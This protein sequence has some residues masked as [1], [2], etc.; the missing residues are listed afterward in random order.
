LFEKFTALW[1]KFWNDFIAKQYNKIFKDTVKD[2]SQKWRDILS[3]NLLSIVANTLNNL[4]NIEATFDIESD[5]ILTEPLKDLCKD[6]EAKRYDIFAET[7]C[8]GDYYVFP[9]TNERGELYHSYLTQEQVRILDM[10]GDKIT[11]AYGIIEWYVDS[12]TNRTYYLLRHHVLDVNGTLTISYYVVDDTNKASSLPQWEHLQDT[13]LQYANANHIGFGR[14]KSPVS[15][16]GLSP[17]YGVPL[18]YGCAE[19]EERIFNTL[20]LM[21]AE[22]EN[23]KSV[24]FTDPRNLLTDEEKKQYKLAENV[25]PTSH[26]SGDNSAYIDIFNPTLRQSEF[27]GKLQSDFAVYEKQLGASKGVLSDSETSNGATAT[28]VRRIN[29]DTIA[30]IG[31]FHSAI[32]D[33]NKMTLEADAVYLNIPLVLWSYV[34]DWYDPFED[35]AA[36]WQR[37]LEAHNAGAITTARLTKWVYPNMTDE[38]VQNELAEISASKQINTD[39]AIESILNGQ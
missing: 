33:G 19:A 30:L 32:D 4:A 34:S 27:Y 16:R 15:S 28:E 37:M 17:V 25:I 14:Y 7:A 22:F 1:R 18:N 3:I 20:K 5:S 8:E 38:E 26:R 13:V 31:K 10:D 29:A 21:D 11:E 9:A 35:P 12:K 23:G 36:Q 24:I 6:L 2:E 39:M